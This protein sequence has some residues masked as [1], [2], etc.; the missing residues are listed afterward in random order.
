[1]KIVALHG[2]MG[3]SQDWDHFFPDLDAIDILS[4]AKPSAEMTMQQWSDRFNRK[5][6]GR[7]PSCL[8]GYS[9]GGR[10]AMHALVTNP[11]A[12][13][14]AIIVSA[15]PGLEEASQRAARLQQDAIWANR[16]EKEPWDSLMTDWGA[17]E[18]FNGSTVQRNECDYSRNELAGILRYWSLG[19]QKN[20]NPLL[21]QLNIPILWIAGEKDKRYAA[22]ASSVKLSHPQS[23]IWIAPEVSHRVPWACKELFIEKSMQFC[24]RV[25]T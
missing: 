15:N 4:I 10:L 7:S 14:C 17:Q 12:W 9:M 8:L 23:E 5:M 22:I 19:Q 13:S 2:F 11:H 20:L 1:M 25:K 3:K 16:F 6:A 21:E 24:K 18:L